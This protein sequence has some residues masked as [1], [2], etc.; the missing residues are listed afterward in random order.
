MMEWLTMK[1]ATTAVALIVALSFLGMFTMQAQ[2]YE[3]LELEDLA[4]DI[5]SL[6]AEVDLLGCE[7]IV[8][9]DWTNASESHGLPRSF[10]GRPYLIQFS[11]ERPYVVLGDIRVAGTYFPSPVGIIDGYGESLDLLEVSS[12]TGFAVFSRP[13]WAPWGLDMPVTISPL[14]V[15]T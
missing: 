14:T 10:H 12:T 4:D 6:V 5:S 13:E 7:A 15:G 11:E 9:V 3:A 8:E 1:V 2:Y